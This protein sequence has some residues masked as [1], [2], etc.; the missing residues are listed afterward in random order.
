MV[1]KVGEF[2][3]GHRGGGALLDKSVFFWANGSS[4][5]GFGKCFRDKCIGCNENGYTRCESRFWGEN[6]R[7]CARTLIPHV[8]DLL[9][10]GADALSPISAR[11]ENEYGAKV[12]E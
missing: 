10:S 5:Y 3:N 12:S 7:D 11:L 9:I 1:R 6:K 8:G 2:P 4:K